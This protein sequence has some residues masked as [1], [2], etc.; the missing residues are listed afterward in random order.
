MRLVQGKVFSFEGVYSRSLQ[1]KATKAGITICPDLAKQ[2]DSVY[3]TGKK[4]RFNGALF[5]SSD[6]EALSPKWEREEELIL[7]EGFWELAT[8]WHVVFAA[9]VFPNEEGTSAV[10]ALG[11]VVNVD[12]WESRICLFKNGSGRKLCPIVPNGGVHRRYSFLGVRRLN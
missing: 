2:I 12:D 6:G 5:H 10:V 8:A 4:I 11:S 9:A 1:A 3:A 7:G